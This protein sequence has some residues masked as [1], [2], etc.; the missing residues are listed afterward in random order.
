MRRVAENLVKKQTLFIHMQRRVCHPPL[1]GSVLQLSV[2]KKEPFYALCGAQSPHLFSA[3]SSFLAFFFLWGFHVCPF[4][5]IFFFP[6]TIATTPGAT[7]Y[8]QSSFHRPIHP[9]LHNLPINQLEF[10]PTLF[11]F[12]HPPRT[13]NRIHTHLYILLFF[14]ILPFFTPCPFFFTFRLL[15]PL[16]V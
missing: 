2:L 5:S 12:S 16:Y 7:T 14:S 11:S 6:I 10:Q 8:T 4:S 3:F 1:I 9:T 13:F 15:H